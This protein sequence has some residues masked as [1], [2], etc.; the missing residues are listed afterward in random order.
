MKDDDEPKPPRDWVVYRKPLDG[1]PYNPKPWLLMAVL[2]IIVMV[3]A[4]LP[5]IL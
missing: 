4:V 1:Q 3:F 5:M 2:V